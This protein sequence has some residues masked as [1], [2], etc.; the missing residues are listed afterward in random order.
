MEFLSLLA[1]YSV[2]VRKSFFVLGSI[3]SPVF[4][5]KRPNDNVSSQAMDNNMILNII[6][7]ILGKYMQSQDILC[8]SR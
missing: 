2:G 8:S 4:E 5:S 3:L 6:L 7:E 1:V